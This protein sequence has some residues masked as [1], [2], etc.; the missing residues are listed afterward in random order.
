MSVC[1]V[2][3][4]CDRVLFVCPVVRVCVFVCL[5]VCV[6]ACVCV[7]FACVCVRLLD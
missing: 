1:V 3:C 4:L 7:W 2:D 5:F 6:I